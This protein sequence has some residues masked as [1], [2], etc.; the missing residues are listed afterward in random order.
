MTVLAGLADATPLFADAR[1]ESVG[2]GDVLKEASHVIDVDIDGVVARV[3][4]RQSVVNSSRT[5][6]EALYTFA[7]PLKAALTGVAV[8]LPGGEK[9]IAAVVDH[10]SALQFAPGLDQL[11]ARNAVPDSAIVR[12]VSRGVATSGEEIATYELRAY[13]IPAGKSVTIRMSW[14][15]PL[16]YNGGRLSLRIPGRGGAAN[17]VNEQ[18]R[19]AVRP[20]PSARALGA[21]YGGGKLLGK[22]AGSKRARYAFAAHPRRDLVIEAIPEFSTYATPTRTTAVAEFAAVPVTKSFGVLALSMLAP[23]PRGAAELNYERVV[24]LADVSRSMGAEGIA[25]T[26]QLTQQILSTMPPGTHVGA[27]TFDRQVHSAFTGFRANN[28]DT[29]ARITTALTRPQLVNGSDLGAALDAAQTLIEG[30]E[31]DRTPGEG[32]DRGARATNLVVIISD[33]MTPLALDGARAI[34]RLGSAV[35]ASSNVAAITLVP[36]DA[37]APDTEIGATA[38]L[39]ARTR[40]RSLVVRLSEAQSRAADITADICRP[41][42]LR[43]TGLVATKATTID[44]DDFLLPA[45]IDAGGGQLILGWYHG[46]PP[47]K[48]TVMGEGSGGKLRIVAVRKPGLLEHNALALALV[49]ADT[50]DLDIDLDGEDQDSLALIARAHKTA[51][52]T[53]RNALVALASNDEFARDRLKLIKKWGGASFLRLPPPPERESWHQFR[54][55]DGLAVDSVG[56][57][58]QRSSHRRTGELDH[59]IIAGLIERHVVPKAK[60]CYDHAL[61]RKG[62]LAGS[63]VVVIEIARG[64][65]QLAEITTSTFAA[66]QIDA[67]VVNA[68]YSIP[69]P[70][71]ALGDD[72]E[73]I[74]VARYPLRFR[75][76]DKQG[77]VELDTAAGSEPIDIDLDDPLGGLH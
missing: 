49:N 22:R 6:Q 1:L 5:T 61:R 9:T 36:D 11:D 69:V 54:R 31:L 73:T 74:G 77:R 4:S 43:L 71:V 34:D 59:D 50:A 28:A 67:C 57:P 58:V 55:Y 27:L 18:I 68:A 48:L 20:P 24:I 26:R 53:R 16:R 14:L 65:V 62:A 10:D 44:E 76:R 7:L 41:P 63:L 12:L 29:R 30:H 13:P 46:A 45:R 52:V 21:V 32:V 39:A 38:M 33:G 40:G 3:E 17:L 51:V 25:A 47:S 35:I 8:D 2:G 23:S 75:V 64:E 70:R 60:S 15:A 19:L 72:P 42:P 56:S 37:P 66:A